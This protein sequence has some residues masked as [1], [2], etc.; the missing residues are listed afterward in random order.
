M[1]STKCVKRESRGWAK[2]WVDTWRVNLSYNGIISLLC[3]N[4]DYLT[5]CSFRL[6]DTM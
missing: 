3:V 4:Q 2:D 6:D 5:F 1:A